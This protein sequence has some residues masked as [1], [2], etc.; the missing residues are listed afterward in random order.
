MQTCSDLDTT[1]F[2]KNQNVNFH[3]SKVK[4]NQKLKSKKLNP[5]KKII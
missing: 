1:Q 2:K 5:K 4:K 3:V